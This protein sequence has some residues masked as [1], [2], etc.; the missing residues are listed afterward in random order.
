MRKRVA[1]HV[2]KGNFDRNSKGACKQG[3][4]A[5]KHANTEMAARAHMH[6]HSVLRLLE[7]PA[8]GLSLLCVLLQTINHKT[9][10]VTNMLTDRN[11]GNT[12]EDKTP[13]A[14]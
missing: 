12:D 9:D 4:E 7:Q 10:I 3:L 1:R 13:E 11:R 5:C 2:P 14:V 6:F 8:T